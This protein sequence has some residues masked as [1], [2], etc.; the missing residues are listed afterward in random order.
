MSAIR[1]PI[2]LY[3]VEVE[4]LEP[5]IFR[6]D[7]LD[8]A[9]DSVV[10]ASISTDEDGADLL[11]T[12]THE[13]AM[14]KALGWANSLY[15]KLDTPEIPPVPAAEPKTEAEV[16]AELIEEMTDSWS[17]HRRAAAKRGLVDIQVS[18]MHLR[19]SALSWSKHSLR[20]FLQRDTGIFS[21]VHHFQPL[22]GEP[23][24]QYKATLLND[25]QQVLC[26]A[27]M[28]AYVGGPGA[29]H[30]ILHPLLDEIMK[31]EPSG[32]TAG[33]DFNSILTVS[34]SIE[35]FGKHAMQIPSVIVREWLQRLNFAMASLTDKHPYTFNRMVADA[36]LTCLILSQEGV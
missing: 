16:V 30:L 28:P 4:K 11:I 31:W 2:G 14:A 22:E 36:Y 20:V 34:E 24:F 21:E 12:N 9:G 8:I 15:V 27:W 32:E 17:G 5:G 29:F 18:V 26:K 10:P 1:W 6:W 19:K 33:I 7:L 13:S 23:D 25:F 35:S 3:I